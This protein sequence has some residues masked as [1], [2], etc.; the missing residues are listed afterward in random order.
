MVYD[1][2]QASNLMKNRVNS[3]EAVCNVLLNAVLANLNT[4][5]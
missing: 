5:R 2:T 1:T 4:P 3:S